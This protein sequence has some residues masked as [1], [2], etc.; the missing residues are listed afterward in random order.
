MGDEVPLIRIGGVVGTPRVSLPRGLCRAL[1]RLPI[2]FTQHPPFDQRA[3]DQFRI[4]AAAVS[5]R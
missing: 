1:A 5:F 4:A 2:H 3:I